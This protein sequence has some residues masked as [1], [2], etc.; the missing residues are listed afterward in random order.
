MHSHSLP[1]LFLLFF[2]LGGGLP[3]GPMGT[4]FNLCPLG[5]L[6]LCCLSDSISAFTFLFYIYLTALLCRIKFNVPV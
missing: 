4:F 2:F 3:A 5:V 6:Q 1:V